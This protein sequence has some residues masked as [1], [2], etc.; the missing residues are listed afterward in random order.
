V[1]VVRA[2]VE[3]RGLLSSNKELATKV[4]TLERKVSAHEHYIAELLASPAPPPKRP[5]GFV[6]PEDKGK[7]VPGGRDRSAVRAT[8]QGPVACPAVSR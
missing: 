4:H 6:T 3:L 2:F 8:S 1:Y 5:I 7:T